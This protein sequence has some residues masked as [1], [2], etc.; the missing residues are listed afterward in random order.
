MAERN[1]NEIANQQ[2]HEKLVKVV[3]DENTSLI[4]FI[5]EKF[6][7]SFDYV[8]NIEEMVYEVLFYVHQVI[9]KNA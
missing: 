9:F 3:E 4:Q 5:T 8:K 2:R 1:V 7:R 6:Y